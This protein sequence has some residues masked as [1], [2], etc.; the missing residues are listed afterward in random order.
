MKAREQDGLRVPWVYDYVSG[1]LAVGCVYGAAPLF[2][3]SIDNDEE[4]DDAKD[5]QVVAMQQAEWVVRS[6]HRAVMH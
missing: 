5:I 1:E 4:R 2:A 3:A 6:A